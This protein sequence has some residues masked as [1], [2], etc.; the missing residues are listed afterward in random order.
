MG[1]VFGLLLVNNSQFLGFINIFF[2][3]FPGSGGDEKWWNTVLQSILVISGEQPHARKLCCYDAL[4]MWE[5]MARFMMPFMPR[6]KL[7]QTVF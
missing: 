7:Y 3:H 2:I 6:T 5:F 1:C 4:V